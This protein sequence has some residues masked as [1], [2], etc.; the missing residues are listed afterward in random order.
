MNLG[1]RRLA[2]VRSK[3]SFPLTPALSL[4]ERE[5]RPP[6]HVVNAP[7]VIRGDGC[8]FRRAGPLNSSR[9]IEH[10][11]ILDASDVAW[12]PRRTALENLED[13][14]RRGPFAE[15]SIAAPIMRDEPK[16]VKIRQRL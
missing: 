5:N 10:A 6:V 14:L 12:L 7:I 9:R 15:Q 16:N 1:S 11:K 3:G 2:L 8:H 13:G 4:W